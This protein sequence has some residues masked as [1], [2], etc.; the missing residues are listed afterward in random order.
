MFEIEP[1]LIDLLL[2]PY[3]CFSM[4]WISPHS[5]PAFALLRGNIECTWS[6]TVEVMPDHMW[7]HFL[8]AGLE[9]HSVFFT[10]TRRCPCPRAMIELWKY[11]NNI[12]VRPINRTFWGAF[13][14]RWG[15]KPFVLG[16]ARASD[17][18]RPCR[19][20]QATNIL[21]IPLPILCVNCWLKLNCTNTHTES[22]KKRPLYF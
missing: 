8:R 5:P 17:C 15:W 2:Q 22:D 3:V 16:A 1:D 10:L 12:T 13:W 18:E 21:I 19:P 6:H 4:H 9:P 14:D 7:S 20:P 11:G